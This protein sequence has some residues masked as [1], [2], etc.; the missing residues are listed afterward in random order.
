MV[1]LPQLGHTT[2]V[3]NQEGTTRLAIVLVLTAF[4]HITLVHALV[5]V[6][7]NG[8][9]V[10]TIGAWHAIL[11]I[12]ARDGGILL[13]EFGCVEEELRLFFRKGHKGRERAYVVLQV[14]HVGHTA[15]H[16]KHI[17]LCAKEAECPRGNAT[18][19]T[20]LFQTAHDVVREFGQ[21][22]TKERFHHH[23]GYTPLD[24]L[25]VEVFGTDAATLG[26]MPVHIVHLQEHEVPMIG[27]VQG[28]EFV[29]HLLGT[30]ERPSKMTDTACLALLLE[31]VQHTVVHVALAEIVHTSATQGVKQIVVDVVHLQLTEGAVIHGQ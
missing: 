14:L 30:V 17:G 20:A 19:G 8:R 28:K 18:L 29:E 10:Y 9:N 21:T 22:A 24:A 2:V 7:E 15:E 23:Y 26:N 25:C 5:V 4:R 11:A 13:Y 3:A 16:G 6:Q 27:I 31:E 1:G 12:I